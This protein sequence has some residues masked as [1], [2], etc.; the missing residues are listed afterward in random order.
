[1]ADVSLSDQIAEVKRELRLREINYPRWIAAGKMNQAEADRQ[2]E[3]M[4]AVLA[5]LE[6]VARSRGI[7]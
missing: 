7:A 2:L 4:R 5:T 3:R 6:E 1:M